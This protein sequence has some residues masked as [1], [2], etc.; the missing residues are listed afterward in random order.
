MRGKKVSLKRA[1]PGTKYTSHRLS[2]AASESHGSPDCDF[3]WFRFGASSFPSSFFPKISTDSIVLF[4]TWNSWF[5]IP[6]PAP[7]SI[8]ILFFATFFHHLLL[9]LTAICLSCP[10][11][12]P[13][14]TRI[15][16][17]AHLLVTF[18]C[19][20]E[21]SVHRIWSNF[22]HSSPA[23]INRH[24]VCLVIIF[25]SNTFFITHLLCTSS[26]P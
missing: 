17:F 18:C 13:F 24:T 8:P 23:G 15:L 22:S 12:L 19:F 26:S 2:I 1:S 7:L 11:L 16:L 25:V 20:S 21:P 5:S 10:P 3:H 6:I 14:F 9:L 4:P